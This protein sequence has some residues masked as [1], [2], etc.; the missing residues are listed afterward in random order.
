MSETQ[1]T[2]TKLE[3][4]VVRLFA[5]GGREELA[6]V[7]AA[8]PAPTFKLHDSAGNEYHW[9]QDLTRAATPEEAV[10]Y[11]QERA[12]SAE[13]SRERLFAMLEKAHEQNSM[14]CDRLIKVAGETPI[15]KPGERK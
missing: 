4:V 14:L 2:I 8:C 3:T 7:V 1:T 11:W 15:L 12:K 9:R 10:R 5:T 13:A 6:L